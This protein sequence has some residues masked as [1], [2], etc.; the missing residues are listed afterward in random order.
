[1]KAP[2][3]ALIIII[4]VVLTF[5][6]LSSALSLVSPVFASSSDYW[7]MFHHDLAHTGSSTT[8]PTATSPTLL[9]NYT[10]NMVVWASPTV[11]D[12]RVYIGSD[13]GVAYCLN[14]SDGSKIWNY[15]LPTT[16]RGGPAIGSSMAVAGGYIYFGC[17]DR[18]VYCLNASTGDKVWNFTTGN[19]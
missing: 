15:T 11:V 17:Y 5:S 13:G 18:N 10:T 16:G 7:P 4:S 8:T 9:W 1:M 3:H 19:S 6:L 2:N 14:A 12:D